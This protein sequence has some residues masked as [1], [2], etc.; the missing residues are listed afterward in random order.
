MVK[1][2]Q[3]IHGLQRVNQRGHIYTLHDGV[4]R[5]I[6]PGQPDHITQYSDPMMGPISHVDF[7]DPLNIIVFFADFGKVVFLDNHLTVKNTIDL[8]LGSDLELPNKL[9]RSSQGGFWAWHP[10]SFRLIRYDSMGQRLAGGSDMLSY[11]PYFER[12]AHMTEAYDRLFLA[13]NGLWVFDR[14]GNFITR[15]PDLQIPFFQVKDNFLL[16]TSSDSLRVYEMTRQ[17][18]KSFLLPQYPVLSFF[19]TD[20]I[21]YLQTEQSLIKFRIKGTI[22]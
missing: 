8:T 4:L 22:F 16:Y 5:I 21:L 17:Q 7:S 2:W 9:C 11:A 15:I 3:N 20:D 18:E 10:R 1:E 14:F 6:R 12:V 13:A 19:L